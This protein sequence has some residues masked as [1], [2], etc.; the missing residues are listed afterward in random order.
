[1][2]DCCNTPKRFTLALSAGLFVAI[3]VNAMITAGINRTVPKIEQ[4]LLDTPQ[5]V[6]PTAPPGGINFDSNRYGSPNTLPVNDAA[7]DELKKQILGRRITPYRSPN[8]PDG[9]CPPG[10]QPNAQPV[11]NSVPNA[12]QTN[13]MQP[14]KTQ[15][16]YSIELFVTNDQQSQSLQSWFKEN[17]T[18]AKWTTTCNHNTYT[19]DNPLY[20]SRYAPLIPPDA[21]P[22]VLV[23]APN[24]GHVYAA[25]R[26]AL[27]QTAAAL[28]TEISDATK[29]HQSIM[30]GSTSP[31]PAQ[32]SPPVNAQTSQ[33]P[34]PD[35]IEQCAD[36]QCP[37]GER[38]PLLDRLRDK[39]QNNVEGLLT[40]I[41]SP[42]EFLIQVIVFAVLVAAVTILIVYIIRTR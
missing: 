1:M 3:V 10:T 27:P 17:S 11:P 29:L 12:Q 41:F 14:V 19:A 24:G 22:V 8:C 18:L 32:P 5:T 6:T 4:Y 38:F 9:A 37:P 36:G 15:Q 16:R 23:T 33:H 20:K 31:L 35:Y 26:Y 39:S 42:T 13:N 28:V 2:T 7:R 30:A 34:A 25:D 21:F 40:A